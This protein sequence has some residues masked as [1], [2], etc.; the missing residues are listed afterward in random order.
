MGLQ[1]IE[2]IGKVELGV[3]FVPF[4]LTDS[5]CVSCIYAEEEVGSWFCSTLPVEEDQGKWKTKPIA[6]LDRRMINQQA[7]DEWNECDF[8]QK[9]ET[10][11]SNYESR[12]NRRRTKWKVPD[13]NVIKLNIGFFR[14]SYNGRSGYGVVARDWLRDILKVW[15][16]SER[17]KHNIIEDIA[18]TIRFPS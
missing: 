9:N 14:N 15:A 13:D 17:N 4:Y 3:G 10:P 18:E 5:S 6:I 1:I 7:L 16:I 2:K 11:E 12:V 8:A